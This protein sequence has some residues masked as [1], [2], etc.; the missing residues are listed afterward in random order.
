[1]PP[2]PVLTS[3]SDTSQ[4]LD[5]A[6]ISHGSVFVETALFVELF[7]DLVGLV[8]SIALQYHV[9]Y[10]GLTMYAPSFSFMTI[11]GAKRFDFFATEQ[12]IAVTGAHPVRQRSMTPNLCSLSRF[13]CQV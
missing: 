2:Q 13:L 9:L 6:N 11:T 1:M 7:A 3:F 10:V 12:F 4:T 8:V 5:H